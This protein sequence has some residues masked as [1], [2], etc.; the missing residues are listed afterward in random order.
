[1]I[2]AAVNIAVIIILFMI[3]LSVFMCNLL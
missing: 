1:V 2:T 3:L